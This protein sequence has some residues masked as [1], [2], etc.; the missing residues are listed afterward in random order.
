MGMRMGTYEVRDGR[1]MVDGEPV[2]IDRRVVQEVVRQYQ[3][4]TGRSSGYLPR[5]VVDRMLALDR[6]IGI[7]RLQAHLH[8]ATT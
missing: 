5:S 4:E 8:M 3:A 7:A 6:A 2:G 1:L